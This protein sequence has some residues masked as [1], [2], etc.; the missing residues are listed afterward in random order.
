MD[1]GNLNVID[2]TIEK[3][4]LDLNSC[5][6]FQMDNNDMTQNGKEN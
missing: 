5:N 6:R 2:L 3:G 4:S 1:K